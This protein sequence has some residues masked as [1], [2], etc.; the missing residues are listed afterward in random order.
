MRVLL[1]LLAA[2]PLMAVGEWVDLF[3]GRDLSHWQGGIGEPIPADVWK[4]EDGLLTNV[5]RSGGSLYSRQSYGQFELEWE[6]RISRGG[7]SGVKYL[8]TPGRIHPDYERLG[9]RPM[10][11]SL[12]VAGAVLAIALL[13]YWRRW[14]RRGAAVLALVTLGYISFA[15]IGGWKLWQEAQH[16]PPGLEYQLLDDPNNKEGRLP[17]HRTASLYDL[18]EAKTNARKAAGEWNQSRVVVQGKVVEHWL[19]GELALRYELGSAA[20]RD[21][22]GHSKFKTT[23]GFGEPGVGLIELQHHG[24]QVWFRRIRVREF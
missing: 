15:G 16:R 10:R 20:V 2:L 3:D 1:G 23:P 14:W 21:A 24:D 18:L 17:T 12:W 13:A 19:N 5:R 4:V 9:F 22:V 6:W 7:N 11:R 8:A